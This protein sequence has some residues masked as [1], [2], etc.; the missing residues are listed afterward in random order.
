MLRWA[1]KTQVLSQA[2]IREENTNC[3]SVFNQNRKGFTK[4]PLKDIRVLAGNE[5]THYLDVMTVAIDSDGI[6]TIS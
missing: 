1:Q 3:F 4:Q 6:E 2:T 5:G